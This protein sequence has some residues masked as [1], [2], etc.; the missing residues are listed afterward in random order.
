[1]NDDAIA[2]PAPSVHADKCIAFAV[3]VNGSIDRMEQKA[4]SEQRVYASVQ[5]QLG[6]C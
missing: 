6:A 2:C 4:Q 1:M 3:D 5:Q